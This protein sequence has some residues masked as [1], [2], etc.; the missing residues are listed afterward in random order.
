M[1]LL[2]EAVKCVSPFR[3]S[4]ETRQAC[5]G[6]TIRIEGGGGAE[7]GGRGSGSM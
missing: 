4:R 5:I 7:T 1:G 6:D 2:P 3:V